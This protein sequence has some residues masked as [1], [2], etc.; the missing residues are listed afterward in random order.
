MNDGYNFIQL[1]KEILSLSKA[2]DWET[3]RKEWALVE[4]YEAD[5]PETCLCGHFPIIEICEIRNRVTNALAEVGNRCVKRFLGFRSDL[6]FDAL[7]R[8]RKIHQGVSIPM[9]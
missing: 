8:I 5:E 3:A 6:I 4:D 9:R 2:E 1:K 7:K